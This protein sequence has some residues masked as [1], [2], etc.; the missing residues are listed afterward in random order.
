MRFYWAICLFVALCLL[1]S[2]VNFGWPKL[3]GITPDGALISLVLIFGFISLL[4]KD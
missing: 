4:L 3:D 2:A 1:G